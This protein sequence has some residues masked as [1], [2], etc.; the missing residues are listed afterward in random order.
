MLE[1]VKLI[2][3]ATIISR[4]Y[5]FKVDTE[6]LLDDFSNIVSVYMTVLNLRQYQLKCLVRYWNMLFGVFIYKLLLNKF[7]VVNF[8]LQVTYLFY[9]LI[10]WSLKCFCFSF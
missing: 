9:F 10:D 1:L 2:Q 3:V 5:K 6:H 4:D 7:K 8:L